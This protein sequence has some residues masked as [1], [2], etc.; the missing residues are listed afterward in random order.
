MR[1]KITFVLS[2]RFPTEKAYGVTTSLTA[3]AIQNLKKFDVEIIT[4]ILDRSIATNNSVIEIRMPFE[5]IYQ[6]LMSIKFIKTLV[7]RAWIPLYFLKLKNVIRKENNLIWVRDIYLALVF[8]TF[9]YTTVCEIHRIP[10]KINMIFFKILTNKKN[11]IFLFITEKL[12]HSCKTSPLISEI[13]PMSVQKSEILSKKYKESSEA[14][15]VGYVGSNHSSGVKL[16]LEVLVQAANL[17]KDNH[18]YIK[19]KLYGLDS[20]FYN[21]KFPTNIEFAGRVPRSKIMQTIDTFDVGIVLYPNNNYYKTSFPIKIV[22]YAARQIPIIASRTIAHQYL[23]GVDKA[24]YFEP[25]S[26]QS[27]SEA[28]LKVLNNDFLAHR[29][30]LNS[31]NWVKNLTYE[32][33]IQS[34]LFR[35]GYLTTNEF[36][37]SD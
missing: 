35:C 17:L 19:F 20:S 34:A 5:K 22:E 12:R 4:P 23:L 15:I 10:T 33:R 24:E 27:L 37:S 28:I 36:N 14:K 6:F 16:N 9:G 21:Q 13:A 25:D 29:M 8:N 2:V 26:G 11:N 18:K 3:D 1:K 7:F 30:S 32:R 31:H